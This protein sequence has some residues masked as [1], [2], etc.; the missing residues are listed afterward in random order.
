M[1]SPALATLSR[2]IYLLP[3]I[4]YMVYR[5]FMIK[6]ESIEIRTFDP[7][8]ISTATLGYTQWVCVISA[9]LTKFL[10]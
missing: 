3:I 2:K 9:T 8:L 7:L 4:Y 5:C 1:C 6:D 10:S